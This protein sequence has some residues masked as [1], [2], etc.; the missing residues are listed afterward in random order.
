MQ[1]SP[2]GSALLVVERSQSGSP[3][4]LRV[5]HQATFG[6]KPDGISLPLPEE[7]GDAVEFTVSSIGRRSH[8]YLIA[9]LPSSAS[10]VST[11]L[12]IKRN[13]AEY[14]FRHKR[15]PIP[16]HSTI[17]TNHNSLVDCFSEVWER[18]P[19]IPAIARWVIHPP[20][21]PTLITWPK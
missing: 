5:F 7:F 1:S 10:I 20:K 14:L 12:R 19:V 4:L 3:L 9:H 11:S 6:Q 17:R 16:R 15:A 8:A 2:D 21:W 18:F 13:E